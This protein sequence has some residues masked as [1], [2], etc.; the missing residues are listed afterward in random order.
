MTEEE[1]E[2]WFTALQSSSHED[3]GAALLKQYVA[4]WPRHKSVWLLL[5]QTQALTGK[6]TEA[7]ETMAQI[8]R[9]FGSSADIKLTQADHFMKLGNIEAAWQ[10]L[11][12]ASHTASADNLSFWKMFAHIA[13]L[14]GAKMTS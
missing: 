5:A 14:V 7:I 1:A 2:T 12:A 8:E 10:Q 3:A 9:Q 13:F 6:L 11:L 4:R